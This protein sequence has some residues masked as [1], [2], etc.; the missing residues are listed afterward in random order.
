MGGRAARC[1]RDRARRGSWIGSRALGDGS[2]SA[3]QPEACRG[4]CRC[5]RRRARAGP[6]EAAADAPASGQAWPG[7]HGTSP[8]RSASGVRAAANPWDASKSRSR[9]IPASR[10]SGL[11]SRLL[12]RGRC[13]LGWGS[14]WQPSCTCPLAGWAGRWTGWG[15]PF[16][17][18]TRTTSRRARPYPIGV[19]PRRQDWAG[20]TTRRRVITGLA[21]SP[22]AVMAGGNDTAH[23]PRRTRICAAA[24]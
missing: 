4:R 20:R 3:S 15:I 5:L 19:H 13:G 18:I 2:C 14:R 1:W 16:S 21:H 22:G 11:W 6:P 7:Q 12:G 23:R 8:G 9:H 10:C 24:G 17:L